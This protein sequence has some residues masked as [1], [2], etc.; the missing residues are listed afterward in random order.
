MS[1]L[2]F[3]ENL[4]KRN[5]ITVLYTVQT[6]NIKQ[7]YIHKNITNLSEMD[8]RLKLQFIFIDTYSIIDDTYIVALR[9]HFLDRL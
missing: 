4:I 7:Y 8:I 9:Y 1:Y 3:I 6:E 5:L 2:D